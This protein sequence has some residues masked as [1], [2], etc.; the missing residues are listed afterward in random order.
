MSIM[1]KTAQKIMLPGKGILAS[2]ER[3]SSANR[4]LIKAGIKI[5]KTPVLQVELR[6]KY[7]ELFINT[8][9]IEKYVNGVILHDETFWQSD[10]NGKSF[11]KKL[12]NKDILVAIKVDGGTQDM[13]GF[14]GEKITLGLDGLNENLEKYY[15]NGAKLA[16]WRSVFKISRSTP[17]DENIEANSVGLVQYAQICQKNNIVPI[18]EP[19]VLIDGNHSI[20]KAAVVTQKVLKVLFDKLKS[21]E[22]DLSCLI[23][24]SSM[25]IPG[26]NNSESISSKKI[27]KT[28]VDTLKK[29]VPEEVPGIVFLSGGQSSKDATEN[30]DRIAKLEKKSDLPWE[31]AF[32][33]LRAIEGPATAIWKGK[34]ENIEEAREVFTDTL[35]KLHLADAGK[36]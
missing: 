7:R 16:K 32:S 12:L 31:I 34:D 22:V 19:E 25:V 27:A 2:D 35:M 5:P 11:R 8:P 4:N 18:V 29:S 33:Y 23:L 17:S 14:K 28:T 21:Y 9:N 13:P 36:L 24:K 1:K 6:R 10:S 30:L 3:P 20:E 15:E 26:S